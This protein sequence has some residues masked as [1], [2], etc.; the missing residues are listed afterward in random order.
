[1]VHSVRLLFLNIKISL[2]I[3]ILRLEKFLQ[4]GVRKYQLWKKTKN[5]KFEF[6]PTDFLD[7]KTTDLNLKDIQTFAEYKTY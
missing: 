5:D 3:C 4:R 1:M 2:V 6:I 7:D